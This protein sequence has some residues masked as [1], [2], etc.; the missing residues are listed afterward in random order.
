M[1]VHVFQP[2][3]LYNPAQP[4]DLQDYRGWRR[5]K[6]EEAKMRRREEEERKR[7]GSESEGS[8][9]SEDER[10]ERRDGMLHRRDRLIRSC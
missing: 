9:Y 10:E 6:R 4:N 2:D 3:E 7:R 8:Y 1:P 5:A